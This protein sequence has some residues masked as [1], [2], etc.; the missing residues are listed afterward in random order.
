MPYNAIVPD[1]LTGDLEPDDREHRWRQLADLYIVQ[2]LSHY[3]PDYIRSGPTAER[4]LE[5]VERFE[6]RLTDQSRIH[7]PLKAVVQVGPAIEVSTDRKSCDGEDLLTGDIQK[8]LLAMLGHL[9]DELTMPYGP[10]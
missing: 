5:T 6:E 9:T 7:R 2:R 8:Q 10:P 1:L 3:P 4:F